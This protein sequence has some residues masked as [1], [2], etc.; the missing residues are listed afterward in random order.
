MRQ[1]WSIRWGAL[2]G[3]VLTLGV[4]ACRKPQ[5]AA[6]QPGVD[7]VRR[8]RSLFQRGES[9]RG[10][11]LVGL[12]GPEKVELSGTVA[13]CARCHGPAGR[14]S[15]EG[16]VEVPDIRPPT[17]SRPRVRAVGEVEDRSRPAYTRELLLRAITQGVSSS[18]RTLGVAMPRYVLGE[19]EGEE[20]LAY[21]SQLGVAAEPGV[22]PDALT[23]GAALPLSGRLGPVGRE[24]EAVLRAALAEVN[25]RGG[26]FRR[27]LELKV[28]DEAAGGKEATAR[29]LE[30][31]VLALVASVRQG[32]PASDELLRQ[33]G[34]PLVLPL[35][36]GAGATAEADSPIFFLYPPESEQARLAVQYLAGSSEEGELRRRPLGVVRAEGEGGQA[37]ARAAREEARRR[38]LA[39][40]VEVE[41][42]ESAL[43]GQGLERLVAARP[44]AILYSGPAAGLRALALALEA[45]KVEEP[46][47]A[48]ASLAEAQGVAGL[49]QRVL[50]VYPPGVEGR[51][52]HLAEFARFLSRSELQPGHVALQLQAYA[53]VQVLVEAL[54][55]VGAEVTRADLVQRLEELRD[56]NTGVTPPIT[57]GVNRHVG[58]QGAQLVRLEEGRLIADS[59][60]VALLP[61]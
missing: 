18:G 21:L 57:F 37:W 2:V 48:P 20:L 12:L 51:E 13:A 26:V 16:G 30:E 46:V 50:F 22:R 61:Q 52:A 1:A 45:R 53:A 5:E 60:W 59:P 35:A 9:A 15:L 19:A 17:L 6:P 10:Q 31:G 11:P 8:G 25:A 28:A 49:R 54:T 7:Q 55:R 23:V 40:P 47:V 34:A 43:E 3:V 32:Q 39:E 33:E 24:V 58:V 29:L 14:G 42:V 38:E 44:A 27:R 56:F 4:S 36:T 41:L